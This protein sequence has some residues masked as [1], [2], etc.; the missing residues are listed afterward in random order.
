MEW[1]ITVDLDADADAMHNIHLDKSDMTCATTTT[2]TAAGN[3]TDVYMNE[4]K[5]YPYRF[6][7][8]NVYFYLFYPKTLS[9]EVSY[10]AH[11]VSDSCAL[12]LFVAGWSI[13]HSIL[14]LER[15]IILK[16]G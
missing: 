2:K 16:T 6:F 10:L 1:M 13:H 5:E 12:F 15:I 9:V 3:L 14:L 11:F 7:P 8:L 4:M